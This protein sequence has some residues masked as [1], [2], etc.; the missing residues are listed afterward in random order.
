MDT[1]ITDNSDN[2]EEEERINTAMKRCGY[3]EWTLKRRKK[4]E[5]KQDQARGK[6]VIPYVKSLSEKIAR[7]YRKYNIDTIHK[8]VQKLKESGL[9]N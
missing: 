5:K 1:I 7:T 4:N 8:P 6:V 3:P 9:Q 2:V